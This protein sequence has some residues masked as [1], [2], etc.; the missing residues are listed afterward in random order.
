MVWTVANQK[1]G[2]AKTTTTVALGGLA[3]QKNQRVLLVDF[4]PSWFFNHL[5]WVKILTLCPIVFLTFF[6]SPKKLS[7]E[8]LAQLLVPT[9]FPNLTGIALFHFISDFGSTRG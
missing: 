5:L 9:Q 7:I 1:G 8:L 6:Q 3:S 2:V 4:G